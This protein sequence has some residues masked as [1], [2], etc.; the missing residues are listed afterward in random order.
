MWHMRHQLLEQR[1]RIVMGIVHPQPTGVGVVRLARHQRVR[2][3]TSDDIPH[4]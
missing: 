2:P 4:R 3:S 1:A